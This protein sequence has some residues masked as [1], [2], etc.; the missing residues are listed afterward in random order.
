MRYNSKQMDVLP[1]ERENG[2]KWILFSVLHSSAVHRLLIE[3]TKVGITS[4]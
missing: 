3:P 2:S 4:N 1:A